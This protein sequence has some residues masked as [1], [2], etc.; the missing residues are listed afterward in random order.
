MVK[1]IDFCCLKAPQEL[2]CCLIN[3]IQFVT[4]NSL[5]MSPRLIKTNKKSFLFC[6]NKHTQIYC[7]VNRSIVLFCFY[8]HSWKLSWHPIKMVWF[9]TSNTGGSCSV[10]LS[11]VL[12]RAGNCPNIVFVASQ[13]DLG[14][15]SQTLPEI[16][17]TSAQNCQNL[18][19]L[20]KSKI[21]I[22]PLFG[23]K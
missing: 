14:L 10:I 4:N 2:F 12:P 20:K 3:N 19:K 18:S 22:V 9:V 1:D 13:N 11:N 21:K 23:Q 7:C 16:V 5:K 17:Q 8:H 15:M 6:C